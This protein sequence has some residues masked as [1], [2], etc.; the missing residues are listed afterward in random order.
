MPRQTTGEDI[1]ARSSMTRDREGKTALTSFPES[2]PAAP[3][4]SQPNIV[5]TANR[6]TSNFGRMTHL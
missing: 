1:M 4:I 3:A 6:R 5:L 2:E